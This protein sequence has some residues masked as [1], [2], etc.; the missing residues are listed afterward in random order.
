M[1]SEPRDFDLPD[2]DGAPPVRELPASEPA[3]FEVASIELADVPPRRAS[4]RP[5]LPLARAHEDLA[6]V[7]AVSLDV[8]GADVRGLDVAL[9]APRRVA[10]FRPHAPIAPIARTETNEAIARAPREFDSTFQY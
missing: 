1:P 2:L 7:D 6:R 4:A 5:T 9:P 10:S 3:S 8:A